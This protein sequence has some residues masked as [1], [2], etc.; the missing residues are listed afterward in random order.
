MHSDTLTLITGG[1]LSVLLGQITATEQTDLFNLLS[2]ISATGVLCVTLWWLF[3]R[4]E[5]QLD[6]MRKDYKELALKLIEML[7][8][9]EDNNG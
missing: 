8:D 5:T 4:I 7:Q 9:K 3:K 2:N 1:M 6:D